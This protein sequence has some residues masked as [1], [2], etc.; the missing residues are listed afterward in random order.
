MNTTFS[1]TIRPRRQATFPEELLTQ[2]G[3]GEG[4]RVV[5][6]KENGT[7]QLDSHRNEA[8]NALKALQKAFKESGVTEEELDRAVEED[9]MR[10]YA[11]TQDKTS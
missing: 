2:L 11:A 10:R 6:K 5:I 3:I 4:D 7:Y 1:I 8:L 9:R